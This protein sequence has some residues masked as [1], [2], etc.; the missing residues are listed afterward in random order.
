MSEA[1]RIC[2]EAERAY[3]AALGCPPRTITTVREESQAQREFREAWERE[4]RP[5]GMREG[6]APDAR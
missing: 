3:F 1:E 4:Y 2:I 5:N 6:A